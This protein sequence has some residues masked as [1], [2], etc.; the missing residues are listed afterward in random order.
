M[1][2]VFISYSHDDKTHRQR[3]LALAQ[4]LRKNGIE[5]ELDQF[6]ADEIVD[7]PRWCNEQTSKEHSDFVL[8]ICTAEYRRRIEGR[9]PPEKGKGA[10]WEG[11]LL[12]D[13]LY[14]EKGNSRLIP[15]LFDDEPESSI[16]RFLRGWTYCRLVDFVLTDSRYEQLLRIITGK[17]RVEKNPLGKIPD[18][19]PDPLPSPASKAVGVPHQIP[20]PPPDFTG[21]DDELA[22]LLAEV[23]TGGANISGVEGMAGVGKTALA[24]V[25]AERLAGAYPAGQFYF[26]LRGADP[27]Q[28]TPRT[29]SEAMRHVLLGFDPARTL[30]DDEDGLRALYL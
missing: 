8:C 28:Q 7:W 20:S 17:A 9:V 2:K 3:V 18:L 21:R 12:D 24:L 6:H 13:D 25:L 15:V 19:P 16:V 27:K 30:P 10:Y 5:V 22:Q 1:P 14:D 4:A 29:P 11:A 26:D 23:G